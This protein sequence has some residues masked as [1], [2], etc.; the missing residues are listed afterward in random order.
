[1]TDQLKEWLRPLDDGDPDA[2]LLVHARRGPN[3]HEDLSLRAS[4]RRRAPIRAAALLAVTILILGLVLYGLR[5]LGSPKPTAAS[6]PLSSIPAGWTELP[7][8]PGNAGGSTS[9][10]A[11]NEVID[12]GGYT[13][14]AQTNKDTYEAGG[15]AFDP[16]SRTWSAIPPAPEG[17]GGTKAIWT[18]S[19]ALFLFGYVDSKSS[20]GGFAFDPANG[21]WQD[22]A[23][24]P[25]GPKVAAVVWTGQEV[26]AVEA[27]STQNASDSMPAAAYDPTTNSWR[28]IADCPISLSLVNGVWTGDQVILF[29]SLLDSGNHAATHT[30][31]GASY[32][33]TSDTWAVLPPSDLSPQA[34][35]AAWT[36]DRMLAWDYL[37]QSQTFD[38]GKSSWSATE[39][40]PLD[41][42]ECYPDSAGLT[43]YVFAFYCGEAALYDEADGAWRQLHGGMLEVTVD[44]NAGSYQL[45]RFADLIPAESVV[46]L[47]ASGITVNKNGVPC[48][49][50]S[51]SPTSFWVYRPPATGGATQIPPDQIVQRTILIHQGAADGSGRIVLSPPPEGD[52]D[53]ALSAADALAEFKTVDPRYEAADGSTPLL[54]SYTTFGGQY[55]DRF[56]WGYR[57]IGACPISPNP[58][59]SQSPAGECANWLF[60][61][62]RTGKMLEAVS[63][64]IG[65]NG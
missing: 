34:T 7:K 27:A 19:S 36:G 51:G 1:M 10:W 13:H 24:A 14:D 28:T 39:K 25:I 22:V 11:G 42:S 49:G 4:G 21:T 32:D 50:C 17:R 44:A 58:F 35:S 41:P 40:M 65:T 53:K 62:A 2:D 56:A 9:V 30:S 48:Y 63:E 29:G 3:S 54:G 46:F 6:D 18:G 43:G 8:P 55:Q 60:L 15:Y 59:D 61:D 20:N 37:L 64:P 52:I 26:I 5:D 47:D 23:P 38:P 12:W 31:V 33:P 57:S 16:V 45:W